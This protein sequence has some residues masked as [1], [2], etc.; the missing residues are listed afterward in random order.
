MIGAEKFSSRILRGIR[1]QELQ[2]EKGRPTNKRELL[3]RLDERKNKVMAAF[4]K[5]Y[6]QQ[7][8]TQ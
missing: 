3:K 6:L 5:R 8:A 1:K 7:R 2:I 4:N